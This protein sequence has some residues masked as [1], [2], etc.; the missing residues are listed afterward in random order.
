MKKLRVALIYN[1]Y[2]DTPP[3]EKADAEELRE[4][5]Q[6]IRGIARGLRRVGH[7][8]AVL[9][10]AGD[11]SYLQRKLNA[12]RPDVVFNQYDDNVHGALYEMRVAAFIR[13]LGY[14]LTGS[15]PP[16]VRA[17][18]APPGAHGLVLV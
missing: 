6:M 12:L 5:H 14:P 10:L 3:N 11:L 2:D 16:G 15:P 13:M 18:G 17:R 7:E 4:L 8:V 9:P 1:A